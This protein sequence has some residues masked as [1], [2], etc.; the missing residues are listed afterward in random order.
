M[1]KNTQ[2]IS[3]LHCRLRKAVGWKRPLL[4][5][6][7][8]LWACILASIYKEAKTI[9]KILQL[10]MNHYSEESESLVA[11][12]TETMSNSQTKFGF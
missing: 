2:K 11:L 7:K 1:T 8:L 4:Y 9:I 3:W 6:G 12:R 5:Y 10:K